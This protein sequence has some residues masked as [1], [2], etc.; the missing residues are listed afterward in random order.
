MSQSGFKCSGWLRVFLQRRSLD[1]PDQRSLYE[2]H[3]SYDEY[4]ELRQVLSGLSSFD[5]AVNELGACACLALFCSEWYRREYRRDQGWTWE[6]IWGELGY[7]LSP[8]ELGK[9]IP[10]GLERFWKRPLH[11][12]ESERRDFLGTVFSEGGLP[13]HALREEGSRFQTLFDRVLR[14]Y[15][16]SHLVGYS[17]PQLVQAQLEK[18]ALPKV[19]SSANSVELLAHMAD[20]LISL[21]RQY[22]LVQ[23]SE[24]V[25][26]LD[27]MSPRWRELFPLPLDNETG[28]DLLNGLL[29]TA[30]AETRRN[31]GV[32]E[33][34]VC[35]HFW[36]VERPDEFRVRISMPSEV[37]FHLSAQPST[38]RFE[39]AIWEE[40]V[41]IAQ[42]G[43]GYAQIEDNTAR[44]RLRKREVIRSRRDS[45]VPLSLVAMAGGL[46]LGHLPVGGSAI[47]LGDVPVGLE[48]LDDRWQV[49]GQ[50]SFTTKSEDAL[51]VLPFAASLQMIDQAADAQLTEAPQVCS[52]P[53]FRVR[54]RGEFRVTSEDDTAFYRV[55]TGASVSA[56]LEPTLVGS[57]IDWPV[58]PIMT[59]SGL[60]RISWVGNG[61]ESLEQRGSLYVGRRR[62]GDGV[63]QEFLGAQYLS[64]RNGIG[65]ILFRRK[66]GVL[67]TDFRIEL[68][69]GESVREGSVLVYTKHLCILQVAQADVQVRQVKRDNHKEL[70][71]S[72]EGLP[73]AKFRL[74]V[75]PN[76]AADPV[77]LELPFPGSGC[78]AVDSDGK[79]LSRDICIE[80]LLGARL[81]LFPRPGVTTTFNLNLGLWGGVARDAHYRWSY[82]VSDKPVEVRLF[83]I[84]EQILDLLSLQAGLDQAVEL[85]V[86]AYGQETVL[87]IRKYAAE[88]SYDA[89]RQVLSPF[90]RLP[91]ELWEAGLV[92]MALDEPLQSVVD[93]APRTS[94]GVATG[95]FEVPAVVEKGG[96]WLV[97][98][99]K[100]AVGTFR[101][102]FIPGN[103]EPPHGNEPAQTLQKAVL[104]FDPASPENSFTPVLDA[105]A[106]NPMHS[107]WQFL[108][109]LYDGFGYLPL[110]TYEVWKALVGHPAALSMALFKFEAAPDFLGRL[111]GEFPIMWELLPISDVR[112]AV[113][114]FRDFMLSK[115]VSEEALKSIFD[116]MLGSIG[117]TFPSYGEDVRR[118]L[119]REPLRPESRLPLA[120][121]TQV[122]QKT[123]YMD[124]IR[125]RSDALWPE[126][127][128]GRLSAWH[129]RQHD[130]V[131]S[132]DPGA[133]FRYA[134]VYLPVFAAAVASGCASLSEVF[135][136]TGEA[137]FFLR[138]VRDFDTN[139]FDEVYQQSLLKYLLNKNESV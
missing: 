130:S 121:I 19:F 102:L 90:G 84:R 35:Q 33:E 96:P 134:V 16:E 40:G 97:I 11:I 74:L 112:N 122:V 98:P 57:G 56:G 62:A 25:A 58:K 48:R 105:M 31:K 103:W 39:L 27:T 137:V 38:T 88:L 26:R 113:S 85:R 126:Y 123:W 5:A 94:E 124:L 76:L 115:G 80:N 70:I 131:I 133:S 13:F 127:G 107:G 64:V 110:A 100:D 106:V 138:Q 81:Y 45:A 139:W 32:D 67:P 79:A 73:P 54:G 1:V 117:E 36:Q 114:C 95:E 20:Q 87:R 55:R 109:S 21:V 119:V 4:L 42:L 82:R 135:A 18:I 120:V 125:G 111:E 17:T 59:F 15:E 7:R 69:S 24:P 52:F 14:Q 10:A 46:V 93:I 37:V 101:P 47:G 44:V 2:Y 116:R 49:C 41:V 78:L 63:L 3:C 30:T 29:K 12:Y 86:F 129:A 28:T 53:A 66:V 43:P 23:T 61:P 92:L 108:R 77:E 50:A 34:W 128:G 68:R 65:D 91:Q 6:P 51:I 89:A 75:T 8:I 136:D 99:R 118:Y 83:N 72:A 71:L 132:F 60:P 9:V 104:T 22:D